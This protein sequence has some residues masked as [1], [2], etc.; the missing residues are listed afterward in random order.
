MAELQKRAAWLIDSTLRDGEQAA[1]V[2]FSDAEKCAIAQALSRMG[3]P[4]LEVGIP[5]MGSAEVALIRRLVQL[6]LTARLTGWCRAAVF[7][8]SQARDA[9]LRSVHISF[10]VSPL[11]LRALKKDAVWVERTMAEILPL[12]RQWFD[13]VSVGAQ[14][15]SRADRS[16]LKHFVLNALRLGAERIRVADTV[17]ILDPTATRKLFRSLLKAAPGA[18]LEFHGHNDLG[19]ATANTLAALE[20]GGESASVTVNGIGERA[21]NAAL[22]EVVMALRIIAGKDCGIATTGLYEL[23]QLVATAAGRIIPADK[24]V[25]GERVFNHES[26]I[27]G[28]ALLRDHSA[29]EPFPAGLV[30]HP[31]SQLILGK[32]SGTAM[33]EQFFSARGL[34][35]E[36]EEVPA[37]LSQIRRHAAKFKRECTAEEVLAFYHQNRDSQQKL[38]S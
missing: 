4:E 38:P 26:G 33:V 17:G 31:E 3:V 25:V 21:G 32:H 10:P 9:G 20:A 28:H 16:F 35:I 6:R 13:H 29:Y 1:G 8:L 7:D 11:H 18:N 23:S 30:G 37:V 36:K 19:M 27:H 22:A 14:D 34:P 24:P 2:V 15:A 5:A 12:A